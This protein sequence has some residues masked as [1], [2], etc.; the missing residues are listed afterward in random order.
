MNSSGLD[1]IKDILRSR[2][3]SRLFSGDTDNTFIQ[4]FR[5]LFVGGLAAV[6][7]WGVSYILFRFVFHEQAALAMAANGISFVAG[8][9]V[10]Y[11]LSTFWIFKNSN[12]KSRLSEFL[13]F[14]AIGLVGLLLTIG[15]TKLFELWLSDTTSAFQIIAKIV[16]TGVAFFW[17]FF[18][19]KIILYS[20][21]KKN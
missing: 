16:S 20:N 8:L 10:N 5:Y 13:V 2:Q 3:F 19:R 14:A 1:E 17:N 18:A 6:V 21:K 9:A 4:F 11:L 7:D 12:V 15:I